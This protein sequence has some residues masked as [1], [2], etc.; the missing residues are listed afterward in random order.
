M[1]NLESQSHGGLG[2]REIHLYMLNKHLPIAPKAVARLARHSTMPSGVSSWNASCHV[3]SAAHAKDQYQP[4][5]R[6]QFKILLTQNSPKEDSP[7]LVWLGAI[8]M[9][10]A[11]GGHAFRGLRDVDV[12]M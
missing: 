3:I 12:P 9:Q 5:I 7:N 6:Q 11:H 2:E 10:S 4:A 1:Q 8:S